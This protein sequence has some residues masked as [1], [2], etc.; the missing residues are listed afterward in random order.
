ML[1]EIFSSP[2]ASGA[3]TFWLIVS[4]LVGLGAG[5]SAIDF[6]STLFKKNEKEH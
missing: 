4:I 6:R 3:Q 2:I 5:L 1:L